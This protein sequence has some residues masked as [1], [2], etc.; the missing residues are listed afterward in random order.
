M[1]N[2]NRGKKNE[3]RH[4]SSSAKRSVV[5]IP[6]GNQPGGPLNLR[7]IEAPE[8]SSAPRRARVERAFI[9]QCVSRGV[10]IGPRCLV[11]RG[12]ESLRHSRARGKY[13]RARKSTWPE[14][15]PLPHKRKPASG[16]AWP[17]ERHLPADRPTRRPPLPAS[18]VRQ[19]SRARLAGLCRE[20]ATY[21][22]GLKRAVQGGDGE[23]LTA[24]LYCRST[25]ERRGEVRL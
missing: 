19:V 8:E 16:V 11:G 6:L 12:G 20:G 4:N 2:R 21:R 24:R 17:P 15:P 25:R 1:H 5:W 18:P 13:S 9:T 3:P 14:L 22:D 10:L 23:P 7:M